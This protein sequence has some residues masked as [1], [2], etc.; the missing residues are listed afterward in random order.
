MFYSDR[1][2]KFPMNAVKAEYSA[3]QHFL[4]CLYTSLLGEALARQNASEV[5]SDAPGLSMK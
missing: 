1:I 3:R 5:P 2:P 4:S